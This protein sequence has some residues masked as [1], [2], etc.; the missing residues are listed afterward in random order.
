VDR[1]RRV[2]AGEASGPVGA[3]DLTWGQ[4]A[5]DV[6]QRLRAGFEARTTGMLTDPCKM[7]NQPP[8]CQPDASVMVLF[9]KGHDEGIADVDKKHGLVRVTFTA[10]VALYA[11]GLAREKSIEALRGPASE[12]EDAT[13]TTWG[14]ATS[15]VTLDVRENKFKGTLSAITN[16][17]PSGKER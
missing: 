1:T 6:E 14:D 11:D 4:T 15:D 3:F 17:L 2:W 9:K 5:P 8:D 16:Y 13:I 12:V 10:S 7:P